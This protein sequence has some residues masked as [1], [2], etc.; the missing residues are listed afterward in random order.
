MIKVVA[1]EHGDIVA[2]AFLLMPEAEQTLRYDYYKK[3]RQLNNR[4][5][6]IWVNGHI[7]PTTCIA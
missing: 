4:G 1:W 6:D 7:T 2:N 3:M 5:P